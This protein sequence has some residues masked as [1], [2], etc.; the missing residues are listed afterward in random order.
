MGILVLYLGCKGCVHDG[1]FQASGVSGWNGGDGGGA[2][3][4][5]ESTLSQICS[6]RKMLLIWY[7]ILSEY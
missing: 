4:V 2:A 7:A 1:L 5:S 3:S 6:R